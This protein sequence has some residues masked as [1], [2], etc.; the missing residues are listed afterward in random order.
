[1]SVLCPLCL[2]LISCDVSIWEMDAV[3]LLE[4]CP[5]IVKN[6]MINLNIELIMHQI[7]HL[8]LYTVLMRNFALHLWLPFS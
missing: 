7:I 6:L 4:A 5:C 8:I 2:L 3:E 1:M